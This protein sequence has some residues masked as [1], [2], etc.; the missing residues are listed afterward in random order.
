MRW[1]DGEAWTEDTAPLPAAAPAPAPDPVPSSMPAFVASGLP[2]LVPV[3]AGGAVWYPD[4]AAPAPEPVPVP[5]EHVAQHLAGQAAV[6]RQSVPDHDAAIAVPTTVPTG[7]R[8]AR[9][10]AAATAPARPVGPPPP[11]PA[12]EPPTGL[13]AVP[14]GRRAARLAAAA[15]EAP[16]AEVAPAVGVESVA[17]AAAPSA[18]AAPTL[19]A[20]GPETAPAP[21]SLHIP[22]LEPWEEAPVLPLA[23]VAARPVRVPD[24][25]PAVPWAAETTEA[26][27]RPAPVP[28]SA[29]WAP[30]AP[31]PVPAA[32]AAAAPDSPH[33]Y[34]PPSP[35]ARAPEG[36]WAGTQAFPGGY[37]DA[38]QLTR[39]GH[40]PH[41]ALH[42]IVPLGRSWQSVVAG[43]LGLV[44]LVVWP[45]A[46]VAVVLGAWAM[47]RAR[48]GGHG[49]GRAVFAIVAGVAGTAFGVLFLLSQAAPS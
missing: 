42:W 19:S 3:P 45:L 44:G 33:P 41:D 12:P 39:P 10:A 1:F 14:T 8:A 35:G 2:A 36:G 4:G 49:R 7:R 23:L 48:S 25:A 27:G 9:L 37:P 24:V 22:T 31:A 16:S 47:V 38:E 5:A 29:V 6:P 40:D 17:V 26:A 30:P 20:A 43:Y 15:H 11:P 46:P 28:E 18:D 13:T 32:P 34:A 21:E